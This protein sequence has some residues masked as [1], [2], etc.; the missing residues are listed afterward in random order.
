MSD[1]TIIRRFSSLAEAM[2]CTAYL[3]AHGVDA[4][5]DEYQHATVQWYLIPALG[6]IGVSVP[7]QQE[8]AA[9]QF[10]NEVDT[11]ETE[12]VEADYEE[13]RSYG[14][15]GAWL[16]LLIPMGL[17]SLPLTL[18]LIPF[19]F[20]RLI[21]GNFSTGNPNE[22][23]ELAFVLFEC[24]FAIFLAA[25]FVWFYL[26]TKRFLRDRKQEKASS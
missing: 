10:L 14:R 6:G 20:I 2:A 8:V 17:I 22:A 12:L 15:L 25:V 16:Y 3:N 11:G 4:I 24:L 7:A 23:A 18:V 1:R 26:N 13:P 5:T 21:S 9:R 19:V